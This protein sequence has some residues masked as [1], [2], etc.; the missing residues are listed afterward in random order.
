MKK[1]VL[2]GILL[3]LVLAGCGPARDVPP[4]TTAAPTIGAKTVSP[5]PDTTLEHFTDG[6]LSVSFEKEDAYVDDTG[7]MRM[8]LTVY[9]Y[10][11]YD[12]VDISTLAVGDTLLRHADS[13]EVTALEHTETGA[14]LIN[15]GLDA[16][17]FDLVTDDS[18]VYYE[19]GYSD[20]KSWYELGQVTLRVSVDFAGID[21]ADPENP[22]V[23]LYPGDFLVGAVTNYDFTPYN[24]TLRVAD[25]QVVELH[26]RYT[27]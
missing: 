5:L 9:T 22:G 16:G 12:L 10:D 27:P 4:E 26:R 2:F 6:I 21:D 17:G 15:G 23:R 20:V 8:D 14:V 7:I 11:R 13:V 1:T 3:C 25:G 24:T 18:G 19:M